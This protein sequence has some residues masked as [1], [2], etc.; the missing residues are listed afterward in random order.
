V[1]GEELPV[2]AIWGL[3]VSPDGK[4]LALGTTQASGPAGNKVNTS[5]VIKAPEL[6]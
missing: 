4:L 5:Y 3:A 6:K 2:G 1:S